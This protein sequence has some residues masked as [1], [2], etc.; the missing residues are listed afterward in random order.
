MTSGAWNEQDLL[1]QLTRVLASSGFSRNERMSRFLSFLV[2]RHLQG[3]GDEIKESVIAIEVFSRRPDYDPKLDSIVRTEAARLRARL[4]EYS[5]MKAVRIIRNLSVIDGLAVR[6][7]TSSFAFKGQPRT[8]REAG[9]Q[10]DA[11]YLVEGSVLRAGDQLRIDAQVIRVR[12]DFPVW[13][14]R[15]DRTMTDV[16]AIQDE[17]SLGIVNSL[18]LQLGRGRRRYETSV[19]A[20]DLYLRARVLAG[21]NVVVSEQEPEPAQTPAQRFLHSIESFEGAV[22]KDPFFAPAYAGLASVYALRSVQFPLDHTAD[23]LSKMRVAAERAI[24]LDPLLPD[25][26]HALALVYAREGQWEQADKSFRRAIELDPNRS[27][28]YTDYAYWLLAVLGRHAEALR[29]LH[30]AEKAD[31]LSTDVRLTTALVLIAAS[32]YDD[33]AG[34]CERLP[35]RSECLSRVRSGQGRFGE[36]IHLL[37]RLPELSHNPQTRGFLGFAYARSGRREEAEK[38]AAA[39]RYANEQ[40]LIFAGLRDKD[41]TFDALD[42]MAP[43]GPQRVGLYLDYPELALLRG[44]PRLKVFRKR[45][46]LPP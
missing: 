19:E 12:D 22:A 10:L 13:S 11:D 2:T 33:A 8:V 36:T 24:Q 16:F 34:Y 29:L 31:P 43:L 37:E 17:I 38:R 21:P 23:E 44:D 15:F 45:V 41:R 20:Y 9:K 4:I 39:S 26:H 1:Q 32:R 46:G 30:A 42:R 5:P 14:G 27:T 18:R 7:Q 6:S 3:R 40:A 25:A 28:T 35:A